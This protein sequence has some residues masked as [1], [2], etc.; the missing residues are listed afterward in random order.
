MFDDDGAEEHRAQD[1]D[2]VL[3][4]VRHDEG[5]AV[6]GAHARLMEGART[7]AHLLSEFRVP[8]LAREKVDRGAPRVAGG[9]L[10]DHLWDWAFG[11]CDLVGN[12]GRVQGTQLRREVHLSSFGNDIPTIP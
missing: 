12:T 11:G 5:D 10:Q 6:A 8:E 4:A 1:G 7:A 3:R 2:G 9:D